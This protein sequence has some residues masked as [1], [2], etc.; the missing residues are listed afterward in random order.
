MDRAIAYQR[1]YGTIRLIPRGRVATYGQ[2]AELA[3]LPGHARQVGYALH[4]LPD[5]SDVPW[6]RVVNVQGRVSPRASPGWEESS[7]MAVMAPKGLASAVLAVIPL[8]RGLAGADLVRNFT[9]M[10]VLC[11]IAATAGLIPLM[12]HKKIAS[13]CQRMFPTAKGKKKK[14]QVEEDT[15]SID[16]APV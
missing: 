4:A 16:A 2:I 3:G 9:Y 1:I 10:V 13:V 7:I 14:L 15:P 6:Q 8:E 12:R 5:G 11:S